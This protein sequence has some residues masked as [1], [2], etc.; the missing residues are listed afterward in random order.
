MGTTSVNVLTGQPSAGLQLGQAVIAVA[1]VQIL[2]GE[3]STGLIHPTMLA[4]P[5]RWPAL[6][7]KAVLLIPGAAVTAIGNRP[8][9]AVYLGLIALLGLGTAALIRN[10]VTAAGVVLTVLFVLPTMVRWMPDPDW[11][12][13]LYRASPSPG[14]L[15]T[16][17]AWTA[18]AL[19]LGTITLLTRRVS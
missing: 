6:L 19:L 17:A 10:A 14:H 13:F 4:F 18:A 11:A 5:T 3:Y 2:A 12:T 8:R 16:T 1:G 15:A 7:A 9:D